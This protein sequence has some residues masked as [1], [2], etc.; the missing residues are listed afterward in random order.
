MKIAD[1]EMK[2]HQ[3]RKPGAL[4]HRMGIS[5]VV[6]TAVSMLFACSGKGGEKV[7]ASTWKTYQLP[8]NHVV[9]DL[10]QTGE[11]DGWAVGERG[12]ILRFDGTKWEQVESPVAVPLFALAFPESDR[13]W[14]SGPMG[15]F[16]KVIGM[17]GRRFKSRTSGTSCR[18]LSHRRQTDGL[19]EREV[20]LF[21]MTARNGKRLNHRK[22]WH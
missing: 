21:T 16:W 17:V 4:I 13:R 19:S 7:S 3:L 6:L 11:K 20:P 14:Q 2:T 18:L 15:R 22:K 10:K 12:L 8:F 9:F 1:V 5:L